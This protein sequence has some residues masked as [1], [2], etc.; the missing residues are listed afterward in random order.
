ME[1]VS[2]VRYTPPRHLAKID[3]RH[4]VD[5][6]RHLEAELTL[7][8][9]QFNASLLGLSHRAFIL[10]AEKLGFAHD[11]DTEL[12]DARTQDARYLLLKKLYDNNLVDTRVYTHTVQHL[13]WQCANETERRSLANSVSFCASS[14]SYVETFCE[15]KERRILIFC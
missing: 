5:L 2:L 4:K 12:R 8:N 10:H 7:A 11:Y 14:K 9:V 15:P 13:V 6:K 3:R 1:A